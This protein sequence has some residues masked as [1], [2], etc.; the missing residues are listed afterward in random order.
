MKSLQVLAAVLLAVTPALANDTTA[1]ITTGG[2]EF[3]TNP[4]I[5]MESEELFISKDEIRVVYQFRNTSE[6]DQNILVAFPMPDIVPSWYSD[7]AYPMGLED[8]H[9][10]FETTLNGRPV[11]ATLHEYAYAFGVERSK[12]LKQLG[13]P[14]LP[15]TKQA[16]EATDTLDE[17][18]RAEL[19]HL[20]MLTPDE[21]DEGEGWEKHYYPAWTYK[22][23]YTWEGDFPAGELVT[24]EHKYKPSV[25]GTV[26]VTFLGEAYEGYDPATE[27]R[28]K[29]CTD[30]GFVAAVRKTLTNPDEAYSAPFTESWI[31]Y[32]LTTGGNWSGGAIGKFRLVVDKGSTDNLVSFCGDDIKKIGPTTFEMVK[33]DFWPERELDILIL[34]RNG[35]L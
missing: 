1:V 13:L 11:E 31:S 6:T 17:A 19:L 14:L 12:L 10:Q 29:Y 2:L 23:T 20:G 30:D 5:V 24:V 26:G 27:Y 22:A 21:Y 33:T 34:N 4:D 32:I 15:I 28:T 16:S 3:V 9:F 18:T 7:V 35:D 25:G 8:D